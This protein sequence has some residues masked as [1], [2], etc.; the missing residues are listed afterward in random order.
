MRFLFVIA[1]AVAIFA[2]C[3]VG[4][5]GGATG[6]RRSIRCTS[7]DE[8]RASP[9]GP[10]GFCYNNFCFRSCGSNGGC[11]GRYYNVRDTD[12]TRGVM[13]NVN[14]D[15]DSGVCNTNEGRCVKECNI[16]DDC[17]VGEAPFCNTDKGR[18][19]ATKTCNSHN[20]C[21][22]GKGSMCKWNLKIY[23]KI[24]YMLNLG[25]FQ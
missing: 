20:E 12:N 22:G 25:E 9:I 10:K 5:E 19:V 18:C 7:D 15:C 1:A 3:S 23:L 24:C 11:P 14:D 16:D 4:V 8:C 2:L 21:R 6:P 13:C 17:A